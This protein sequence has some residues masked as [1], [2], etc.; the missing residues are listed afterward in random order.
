MDTV[1][2]APDSSEISMC[3][4]CSKP[5]RSPRQGSLTS[6]L[7]SGSACRCASPMVADA[8]NI[9]V[10]AAPTLAVAGT[11]ALKLNDDVAVLDGVFNGEGIEPPE[12]NEKLAQNFVFLR[13]L[14]EGGMGTVYLVREKGHW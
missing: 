2:D 4:R 11:L 14:G 10:I 12:L 7:F 3:A 1:N 9:K 8:S 5:L 6:W 13:K